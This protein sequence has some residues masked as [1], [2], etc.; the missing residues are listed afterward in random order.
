[1]KHLL[2][3]T[4]MIVLSLCIV[5]AYPDAMVLN[6]PSKLGQVNRGVARRCRSGRCRRRRGRPRSPFQCGA[7]PCSCQECYSIMSSGPVCGTDGKT[8]PGE[9]EALCVGVGVAYRGRCSCVCPDIYQ[10]VCASDGRTYP[11]PC[12]ANCAGV[13]VIYHGQCLPR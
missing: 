8:Y 10:P 12:E 5:S 6:S 4:C 9:C 1:M 3:C 7:V 13:T 11:N 2:C